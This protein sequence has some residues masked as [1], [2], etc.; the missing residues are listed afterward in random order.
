M[1]HKTS[2]PIKGSSASGIIYRKGNLN[3]D[4]SV[5]LR[6]D[7]DSG[8]TVIE[9]RI[10][11]LWQPTS[12]ETGPDSVL[13]G[14]RL[15]LGAAGHHI[16]V[17]DVD[18]HFHFH[19]YSKFDGELSTSEARSLNA[20]EYTE[21]EV[22]FSDTS[23][24]W[25]GKTFEFTVTPVDHSMTNK[26]YFETGTTAASDSV[27]FRVWEGSDDTGVLYFDQ[28]YPADDFPASTVIE[29][30]AD[31]YVEIEAGTTYFIRLESDENFSLLT[32][33][34]ETEPYLAQDEIKIHE[35]DMLQTIEWIDG[36]TFEL[37]QLTIQDRQVYNCIEEGTQDTDF[38]SNPEKWNIFSSSIYSWETVEDGTAIRIPENHQMVV[39]D[40]FHVS[41]TVHLDGSLIVRR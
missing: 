21:Q 9:E 18:G 28:Y 24:T 12:F 25:V 10:N 20:Y 1:I 37:D 31:G 19:T 36:D 29:L 2:Q 23:A 5:R 11:G 22:I 27:R 30:T 14:L 40:T 3:I 38:A 8:Y 32:N 35:D 39:H 13:V 4:G 17:E 33:V 34:A 16:M 15:A 26:V 7:P 41:G 6:T